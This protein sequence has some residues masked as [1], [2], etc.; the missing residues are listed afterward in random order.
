VEL[1]G[2]DVFRIAKT[3]FASVRR[4]ASGISVSKTSNYFTYSRGVVV[5]TNLQLF[6]HV[7]SRVPPADEDVVMRVVDVGSVTGSHVLPT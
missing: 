2:G 6:P 7:I 3:V 4:P 5:V 1:R